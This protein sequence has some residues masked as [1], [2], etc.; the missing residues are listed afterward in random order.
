[1]KKML[2]VVLTVLVMATVANATLQ[3]SVN[4]R[5]DWPD[6]QVV[7]NVSDH[8]V[9]DIVS[10]AGAPQPNFGVLMLGSGLGTVAGGVNLYPGSLASIRTV[11]GA[12]LEEYVEA[13]AGMGY[14]GVTSII[15]ADFGDGAIPPKPLGP[16]KVVDEVDFHCTGLGEATIWLIDA[17]SF[18]RYDSQVIHQIPEPITMVLL[19]LGG[20]FLRRRK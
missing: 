10:D 9:I 6:T 3:L 14:P 16:G 12:E 2:L 8:A 17:S 5:T 7:L 15:W 18:E 13:L 19:G 1:M 20:L 11:V 4:G